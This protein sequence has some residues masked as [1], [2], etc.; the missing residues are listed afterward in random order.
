MSS[1]AISP[2]TTSS[3]GSL[4]FP[5]Q[6]CDKK[7]NFRSLLF[8]LYGPSQWINDPYVQIAKEAMKAVPLPSCG[9]NIFDPEAISCM[10]AMFHSKVIED[11]TPGFG[12][13]R[14]DNYYTKSLESY[15]VDK[16]LSTGDL[17]PTSVIEKILDNREKRNHTQFYG[18]EDEKKPG[19]ARCFFSVMEYDE[20]DFR[21]FRII[22]NF[23]RRVVFRLAHIT[24]RDI[25]REIPLPALSNRCLVEELEDGVIVNGWIPVPTTGTTNDHNAIRSFAAQVYDKRDKRMLAILRE[26]LAKDIEVRKTNP[27]APLTNLVT[28]AEYENAIEIKK[29][30]VAREA[31][32]AEEQKLQKAEQHKQR[33]LYAKVGAV[34]LVVFFFVVYLLSQTV[35]KR[36]ISCQF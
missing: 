3:A 36:R 26:A 13:G 6:L 10:K 4:I 20:G 11:P 14:M 28:L 31:A 5:H 30:M 23:F 2:L 12:F 27:N 1:S 7:G 9:M 8:S 16:H 24:V 35:G 22:N 18:R 21:Q 25:C 19:H 17:I 15:W 33:V 32:L 29:Q 34:A